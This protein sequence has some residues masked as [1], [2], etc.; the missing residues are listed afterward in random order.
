M[1]PPFPEGSSGW[2]ITLSA[3]GVKEYVSGL[4]GSPGPGN[5]PL[6]CLGEKNGSHLGHC[7]GQGLQPPNTHLWPESG[8]NGW[9]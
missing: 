4:S 3:W 5:N 8:S 9:F 6:A 7:L 1:G 2:P